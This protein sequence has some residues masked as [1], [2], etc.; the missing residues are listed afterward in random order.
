M[1]T[2]THL[3]LF[4]VLILATKLAFELAI[5]LPFLIVLQIFTIV[6][7]RYLLDRYFRDGLVVSPSFNEVFLLVII[8]ITTKLFQ[9][10]LIVV[11]NMATIVGFLIW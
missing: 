11:L 1:Y 2:S 4:L 3:F 8:G 9:I 6:D 5:F 10:L 7:P